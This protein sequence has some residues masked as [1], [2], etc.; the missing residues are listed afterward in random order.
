VSLSE[1]LGIESALLSRFLGYLDA[2]VSPYHAVRAS[3]DEL[4][5]A[6]FR[7]FDLGMPPE[8]LVS[9]TRG[10]FARAGSLVAFRVGAKSAVEGGFH[11]LTAHTDSP[12]LRVKPQPLIRQHGYVRLG[13][14][15]YGGLIQ[16]T[17]TD[18]DL[19]LAGQVC[20]RTPGGLEHRLLDIRRP[21]CRIPNLAIHLSRKVNEDGLKLNAQTELPALFTMVGGGADPF[22]ALLA[23]ALRVSADDILAWDLSVFDVTGPSLGGLNDEFVFSARLDNLASCHAGLEALVGSI[24]GD[25]PDHTNVLA[26]FDHEEIGSRT[27][28][29]ANSR[30]L[31]SVLERVVN[32]GPSG[33]GS[34]TRALANSWLIS[35][36]MC[37]AVHPAHPDKHDPQHMPVVN[38]G[39]CIKQNANKR[40]ATE[41]ETAAMFMSLAEKVGVPV[42][43]FV[44]RSDLSC[45][46]TVGPMVASQLAVRS[47]DVG[48]PMLSMHSVREISGAAD[49][50]QMVRVLTAFMSEDVG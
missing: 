4:E 40:Y 5:K 2:A 3:I 32:D 37:H 15:P 27:A 49:H 43:W 42:Q 6:G 30:F 21:I 24:A 22:R 45:G 38:R 25:P 1:G 14:E 19:G 7:A 35:A 10:Y 13:L 23:E 39:P 9:G 16:A 41:G 17:W 29:G 31:S 11:L 12:N 18:R 36:D 28:R 33:E 8:N 26:L 46:S 34:M 48:N 20:V 47:L 44:N 50:G